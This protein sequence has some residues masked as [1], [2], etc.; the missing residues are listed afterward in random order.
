MPRCFA[1]PCAVATV[2]SNAGDSD[3]QLERTYVWY[4][5]TTGRCYV[6]C[7]ILVDLEPVAMDL[8]HDGSYVQFFCPTNFVFGTSLF[9]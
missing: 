3:L 6:P 4:N 1:Q 8:V 9:L 7:A 2:F 5:E